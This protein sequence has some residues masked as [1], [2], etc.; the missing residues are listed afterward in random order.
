MEQDCLGSV[1]TS[2]F[3]LQFSVLNISDFVCIVSLWEV[4]IYL[5]WMQMQFS[6]EK[7]PVWFRL[8]QN[9]WKPS[10]AE[11]EGRNLYLLAK[12]N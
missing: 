2:K 10:N 12:N 5:Q 8:Q 9:V 3:P 6:E 4:Q 11:T 7:K 1:G